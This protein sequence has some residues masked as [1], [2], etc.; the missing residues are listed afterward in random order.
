M[1]GDS[2]RAPTTQ[3]AA[4]KSTIKYLSVHARVILISL[5]EIEGN[6]NIQIGTQYLHKLFT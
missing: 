1:W 2:E 4:P 5:G 6:V 3:Q